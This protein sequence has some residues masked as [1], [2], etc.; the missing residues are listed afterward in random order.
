MVLLERPLSALT[1][2]SA[3]RAALCARERQRQVRFHVAERIATAER[4]A[5]SE[6]RLKV[7]IAELQHRTRNLVGVV[8]AIAHRTLASSTSLEAFE[9]GFCDRLAA[10]ARV[11]GLLSQIEEGRRISFDDLLQT[12][13][14]G[15]GIVDGEG[16]RSQ[17]VLM[18]P[19]GIPLRSST[20]Q[21][22][23]LGLHELA[24]NAVK[25]GALSRPEGRLVI[26]WSLTDADEGERRLHVEWR[27]SGVPVS[28]PPNG[29]PLRQGYG[30]ELIEH[31]LPY[32][33]SAKTT[34]EISSEGVR[35][36]ISMPI[37]TRFEALEHA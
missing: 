30:R 24:T 7:L 16:Q 6:E 5:R 14:A 20:V 18:G 10:L 1:L 35:C 37:S 27:E 3:A 2:V 31:A 19:E 22:L 13:L 23:A 4:L 9:N 17:V 33:L 12:E 15:H 8:R 28:L 34:Y 26:R 25:Y 29:Q 36:T 32:Q 11:N 21:I